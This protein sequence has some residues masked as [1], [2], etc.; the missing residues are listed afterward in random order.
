[1]MEFAIER[2]KDPRLAGEPRLSEVEMMEFAIERM[3]AGLWKIV[4]G[5]YPGKLR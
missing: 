1:M 2:L 5:L 4:R 3:N